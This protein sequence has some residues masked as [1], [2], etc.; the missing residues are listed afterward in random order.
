MRHRPDVVAHEIERRAAWFGCADEPTRLPEPAEP[1]VPLGR[2][3]VSAVALLII[4]VG[5][6]M[7]VWAL[8]PAGA[9]WV[10]P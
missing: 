7:I 4:G 6:A 3:L 9:V 8:L 2:A 5:L 10:Q 1:G